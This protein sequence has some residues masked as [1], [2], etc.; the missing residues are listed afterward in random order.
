[1]PAHPSLPPSL[2]KPASL[3]HP[4]TPNP[5]VSLTSCHPTILLLP[6]CLTLIPSPLSALILWCFKLILNVLFSSFLESISLSMMITGSVS[7]CEHIRPCKSFNCYTKSHSSLRKSFFHLLEIENVL[8][9]ICVGAWY[10]FY[11]FHT[12]D[13]LIFSIILEMCLHFQLHNAGLS[14]IHGRIF[15]WIV[16]RVHERISYTKWVL[17]SNFIYEIE[18][19]SCYFC[20]YLEAQNAFCIEN[21]LASNVFLQSIDITTI[22]GPCWKK[23]E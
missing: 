23:I 17:S 1:M 18:M 3:S 6:S 7:G 16:L 19:H 12:L 2:C 22:A 13:V 11:I 21:P 4:P 20:V 15:H 10:H 5:K 9:R 14:D 8:K